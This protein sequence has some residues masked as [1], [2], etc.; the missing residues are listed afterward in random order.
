MGGIG[1]AAT[2]GLWM[3]LSMIEQLNVAYLFIR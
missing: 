3:I 1:D 2:G